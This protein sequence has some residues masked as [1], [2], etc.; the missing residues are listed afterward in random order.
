[1]VQPVFES[2]S[3]SEA[4]ETLT[5]AILIILGLTCLSFALYAAIGLV[6]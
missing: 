4:I 6:M 1:M 2:Q 3:R 5:F